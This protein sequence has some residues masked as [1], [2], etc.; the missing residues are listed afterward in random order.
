MRVAQ[1][2]K[3]VLRLD[4]AVQHAVRVAVAHGLQQLRGEAHRVCVRQTAG[5]W[6]RAAARQ[7]LL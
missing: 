2:N 6:L 3:D 1:S 7:H 5:R 4:V